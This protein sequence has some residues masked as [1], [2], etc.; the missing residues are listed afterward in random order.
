MEPIKIHSVHKN[1]PLSSAQKAK[2]VYSAF[3]S[4]FLEFYDFC[5]MGTFILKLSSL[6][7]PGHAF[8]QTYG[9]GR[10]HDEEA[11]G[12]IAQFLDSS[13]AFA[14]NIFK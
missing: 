14:R 10:V 4:N 13:V 8:A 7:F 3:F 2:T 12:A 9:S 1:I 11:K 6:F 5:L